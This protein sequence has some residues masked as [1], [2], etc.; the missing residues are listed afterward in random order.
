[1]FPV[2][3]EF[4]NCDMINSASANEELFFFMNQIYSLYYKFGLAGKRAGDTP[5]GS[6]TTIPRTTQS[7]TTQPRTTQSRM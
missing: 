6:R 7:R 5:T 4:L 2:L 1:M 3:I